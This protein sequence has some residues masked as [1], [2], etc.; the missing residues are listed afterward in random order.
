[1]KKLILFSIWLM[2]SYDANAQ[3]DTASFDQ[4]YAHFDKKRGSLPF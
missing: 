4:N 2:I 3:L 1:M